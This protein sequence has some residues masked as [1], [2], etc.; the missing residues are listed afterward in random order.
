MCHGV[1]CH[2]Q[3]KAFLEFGQKEYYLSIH[4][5]EI[6]LIRILLLYESLYIRDDICKN[7]PLYTC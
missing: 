5:F 7:G 4:N 2:I 6:L 3:H 1:L